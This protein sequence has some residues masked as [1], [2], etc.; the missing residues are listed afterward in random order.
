MSIFALPRLLTSA[1]ILS[2]V[3]PEFLS[4]YLS[5]LLL[6]SNFAY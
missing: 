1:L 4:D 6:T 2:M 5:G 3:S